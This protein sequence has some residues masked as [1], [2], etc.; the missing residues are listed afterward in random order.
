MA[1][2][3]LVAVPE[4]AVHSDPLTGNEGF[5]KD[6]FRVLRVRAPTA[7][8]ISIR[9]GRTPGA[10]FPAQSFSCSRRRRS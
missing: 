3:D 5:K 10:A 9:P 1:H 7:P 8:T 4:P 6:G 2:E